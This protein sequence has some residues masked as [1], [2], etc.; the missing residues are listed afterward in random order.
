M[1][2]ANALRMEQEVVDRRAISI[3]VS[4]KTRRRWLFRVLAICLALAVCELQLQL[5]SLCIPAVRQALLAAHQQSAN[6]LDAPAMLIPDLVL[7]VRGN[8]E[9]PGHDEL[10]F[11]NDLIHKNP[12]VIAVGDSQTHSTH[13]KSWPSL[14]EID[15]GHTTYNMGISGWGPA[16]YL[17][18]TDAALRRKPKVIVVGLYL[19]ND[20]AD[21]Y[22]SVVLREACHELGTSVPSEGMDFSGNED[23]WEASFR[24][25]ITEGKESIEEQ[26][27]AGFIRRCRR[28]LSN[29]CRLYGLARAMKNAIAFHLRETGMTDGKNNQQWSRNVQWSRRHP[30][31]STLEVDNQRTILTPAYRCALL[32]ASDK[33]IDAGLKLTLE[34]LSRISERCEARDV[35]MVVAI[36]PTKEWVYDPI[37]ESR[38]EYPGMMEL[39][40]RESNIMETISKFLREREIDFLNV[41]FSLRSCVQ[42]R[43]QPYP[44]S[45][46][47][48]PN[49]V[50]NHAIAKAIAAHTNSLLK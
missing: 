10:G 43:Q 48:H 1:T 28:A 27:P 36:I 22:R 47:G 24:S 29:N 46:D 34:A 21:A 19:G 30:K 2:I 37:I 50:G 39:V 35:E 8:P 12:E 26:S 32:D 33:R 4:S 11:R 13:D 45:R 44:M 31:T 20:I 40:A 3:A 6:D 5:A 18:V 49:A 7:G 17:L 9:Y 42:S 25:Q 41:G 15:T 16:E 14:F 23:S 38:E